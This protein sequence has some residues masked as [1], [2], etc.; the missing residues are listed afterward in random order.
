MGWD[1][2]ERWRLRGGRGGGAWS[3]STEELNDLHQAREMT[4]MA[5]EATQMERERERRLGWREATR[6]GRECEET[7]MARERATRM[8]RERERL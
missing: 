1:R 4:R 8:A 6:M 5:R 7:R 3:L 2:L